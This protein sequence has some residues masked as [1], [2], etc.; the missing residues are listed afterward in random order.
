MRQPCTCPPS[1]CDVKGVTTCWSRYL[2]VTSYSC[3]HH[4][5]P[6]PCPECIGTTPIITSQAQYKP[7]LQMD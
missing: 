4:C 1:T 2:L 5:R 6:I 7:T 3:I